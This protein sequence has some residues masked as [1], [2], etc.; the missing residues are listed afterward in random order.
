MMPR[1]QQGSRNLNICWGGEPQH[2][3][4]L[5]TLQAESVR[6]RQGGGKRYECGYGEQCGGW[7]E[8]ESCVVGGCG[9]TFA[10]I[11]VF[12]QFARLPGRG[13]ASIQ[14]DR[15][16]CRGPWAGCLH[17]QG[18]VVSAPVGSCR[19]GCDR[20]CVLGYRGDVATFGAVDVGR[21]CSH[22]DFSRLRE[23]DRSLRPRRDAATQD[24]VG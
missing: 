20:W 18:P 17:A 13:L 9:S 3:L 14:S 1:R 21:N 5:W 16:D 22:P 10:C 2:T 12:E 8:L 7:H 19:R 15:G 11:E 23:V 4:R 24:D 6:G